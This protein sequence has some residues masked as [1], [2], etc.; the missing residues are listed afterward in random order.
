[1][2]A[3]EI[4]ALLAG[5]AL[6]IAAFGVVIYASSKIDRAPKVIYN[7]EDFPRYTY[8][9]TITTRPTTAAAKWQEER[10]TYSR[11]PKAHCPDGRIQTAPPAPE[12][13]PKPKEK[14]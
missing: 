8:T 11:E 9:K 5:A 4:F 7:Y 12:H 14:S 1:M 3:W 10:K 13:T 6:V 2:L